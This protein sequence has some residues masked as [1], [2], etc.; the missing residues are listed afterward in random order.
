VTQ[1]S[2]GKGR[3]IKP[4]L[5]KQ[6]NQVEHCRNNFFNLSFNLYFLCQLPPR[7]SFC[8]CLQLAQKDRLPRALK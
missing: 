1:A 7:K 3:S 2:V 8:V 5:R 4:L 6:H